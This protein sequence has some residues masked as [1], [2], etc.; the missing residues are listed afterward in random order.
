MCSLC[1]NLTDGTCALCAAATPGPSLIC[2]VEEPKD[3][4]AIER[5]GDYR[6]LYHVLHGAIS[7]LSGIARTS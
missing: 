2:V 1:C 7:P 5:A 4:F 3:V 6:G